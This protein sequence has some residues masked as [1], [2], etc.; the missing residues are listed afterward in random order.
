MPVLS[1]EL[2][3]GFGRY[4][5]RGAATRKVM[6]GRI[7]KGLAVP[8]DA[9]STNPD[10]AGLTLDDL[11]KQFKDQS[12]NSPGTPANRGSGGPT[13]AH[14][15]TS[16]PEHISSSDPIF[17]VPPAGFEPATHGLGNRCSIP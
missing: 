12:V 9:W 11:G 1:R 17:E 7:E 2:D 5:G 3:H 4:L 16:P 15:D 13:A 10:L 6:N 8:S 14:A